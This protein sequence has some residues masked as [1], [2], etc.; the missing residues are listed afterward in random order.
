MSD[1]RTN[2]M[3]DSYIAAHPEAASRVLAQDRVA[4]RWCREHGTTKDELT[5]EQVLEIRALPEWQNA[6]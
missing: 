2:F 1:Q 3:R 6:T 5:P 4:E